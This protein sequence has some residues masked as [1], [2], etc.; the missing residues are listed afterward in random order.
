MYYSDITYYYN[1]VISTCVE[2]KPFQGLEEDCFVNPWAAPTVIEIMPFQSLEEGSFSYPWAVPTVIG[3]KPFQGLEE[4]NIYPNEVQRTSITITS[5]A[6]GGTIKYKPM[7]PE[8][9]QFP[10]K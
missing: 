6:T 9:V 7:S 10:Y 1:R 2:I 5:G 4:N 8:G 3:I